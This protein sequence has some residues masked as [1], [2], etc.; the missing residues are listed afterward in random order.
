M[1]TAKEISARVRGT[2]FVPFRIVM[3]SGEA[4]DVHHPELV[5]VGRREVIVGTP[6]PDDPTINDRASF[7]S[8]LHVTALEELPARKARRGGNGHR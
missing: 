4:Y 3:S 7:L 6:S 8:V 5:I 1:L 2:P